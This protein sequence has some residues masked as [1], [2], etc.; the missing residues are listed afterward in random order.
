MWQWP[1]SLTSWGCASHARL[2]WQLPLAVEFVLR[3]S[4]LQKMPRRCFGHVG[5]PSVPALPQYVPLDKAGEGTTKLPV[6]KLCW[7][8]GKGCLSVIRGPSQVGA[9]LSGMRQCPMSFSVWLS[10]SQHHLHGFSFWFHW[11]VCLVLC[12]FHPVLVTIVFCL[13]S[14]DVERW[15]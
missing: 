10:R 13:W 5:R 2:V 4:G 1:A 3:E 8:I 7:G 6:H 9:S 14:S 11:S 12:Q 15:N